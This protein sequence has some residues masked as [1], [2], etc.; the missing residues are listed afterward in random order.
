MVHNISQW[1][2]ILMHYIFNAVKSILYDF[3]FFLSAILKC[4]PSNVDVP[5][6]A[7]LIL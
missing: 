4:S 5:K 1:S 3:F 2:G 7:F 6:G